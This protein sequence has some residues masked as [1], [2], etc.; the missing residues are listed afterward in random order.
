MKIYIIVAED[1]QEVNRL[2][3]NL[4]DKYG[5]IRF[6]G[7]KEDVHPKRQIFLTKSAVENIAKTYLKEKDDMFIHINSPYI[8][9]AFSK[10]MQE[11]KIPCE[12]FNYVQEGIEEPVLKS[13]GFEN[14]QPL[15]ENLISPMDEIFESD[16]RSK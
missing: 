7:I 8:L 16:W 15:F 10:Y 9:Q 3:E 13:E 1:Y 12:T 14:L 5:Y 6:I 4:R 2:Y 11:A